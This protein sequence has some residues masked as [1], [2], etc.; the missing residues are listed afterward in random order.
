MMRP[1]TTILVNCCDPTELTSP[2]SWP[3]TTSSAPKLQVR[4]V[5][6]ACEKWV[7]KSVQKWWASSN[8]RVSLS[9]PDLTPNP[10]FL[11]PLLGRRRRG[12]EFRRG[13]PFS[14]I[15]YLFVKHFAINLSRKRDLIFFSGSLSPRSRRR[16]TEEREDGPRECPWWSSE[17]TECSCECCSH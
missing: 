11:S 15:L 5:L 4:P 16:Q 7:V 6:W 12:P 8:F 17:D 9:F 14:F 3:S 10:R 2:P 1:G 13:V